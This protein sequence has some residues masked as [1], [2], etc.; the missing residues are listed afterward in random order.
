[1]KIKWQCPEELIKSGQNIPIEDIICF[2]NGLVDYLNSKIDQEKVIGK[3]IFA[4]S[5]VSQEN[6]K[7]EWAVVWHE[8][9]GFIQSYCNTIPTPQGG[10]HE[11][12]F[13]TA[14]FKSFKIYGEMVHNKKISLLTIE[15]ILSSSC[16]V[17]SVFINDP[18]FQGQTKEKLVTN[19][20]SKIIENIVK[21]HF[22]Y[23][24]SSNKV[25]ANQILD[26]LISV[27]EFR[28]SKRSEKNI[29]RKTLVQKLKLPGKLTD[30]S[31]TNAEGTEL[32]IVE[33]D[34]AGGSAKQARNRETQA[35]LPLRGKI[36]NVANSTIEKIATNQEIE[37]LE[38][39]LACGSL[40][41]YD[42]K[43]LR[44]E[45]V[46]IMTDA[47]VDGAHIASLLMTFFYLRMPQLI[48]DG[49]L[50]IAR[51]PLYRLTQNN[52]TYYASSDTHK[53]TL[54]KKINKE[55]KAKVEVGRFK[56]LGE[57]TASQLK[58]TTMEPKNRLLY[59]VTIDD[60]NSAANIVESLMGKKSD[61]R[62]E[63]VQSQLQI[64]INEIINNL[65]I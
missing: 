62:F 50:H 6:I 44:Y 14:L 21:D 1:M 7:L 32:F 15:D 53:V 40:Q 64:K 27:A 60:A 11:Q 33:G 16:I 23:W 35:V 56:G 36:L 47:D 51:P 52:K 13:K 30:C 37:D 38:I 9:E 41:N 58:E 20:I 42:S 17:I 46:I 29:A 65:D 43:N 57:M 39:A 4:N 18:Q 19:G 26:Y 24:L 48:L 22:D 45:K 61:K 10:T 12:G 34:S 5:N 54:L 31:R 25:L 8:E 63:F 28:I 3:Q 49:H 2:P 59:K 55:S